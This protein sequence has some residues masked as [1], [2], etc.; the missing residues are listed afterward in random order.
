MLITYKLKLWSKPIFVLKLLSH[1]LIFFSFLI[2]LWI[3]SCKN[4]N[5]ITF[6]IK[7]HINSQGLSE[8]FKSFSFI[9]QHIYL[10]LHENS[11]F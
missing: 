7:I 5:N 11:V 10:F 4:N 3:A 9:F 8:Y 6:H 1:S 2:L